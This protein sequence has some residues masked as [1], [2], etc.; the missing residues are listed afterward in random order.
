[1]VRFSDFPG[2]ALRGAHE[3]NLG[4]PWDLEIK[5][6]LEEKKRK[7]QTGEEEKEE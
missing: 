3:H 1:M 2:W 6:E 5:P 7:S 4:G